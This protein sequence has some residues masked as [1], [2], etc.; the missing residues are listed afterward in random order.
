M[1]VPVTRGL[2]VAAAALG[3]VAAGPRLD[4]S[5]VQQPAWSRIGLIGWAAYSRAAD[6]G[7]GL[8][9]HPLVGAA[10]LVANL[11]AAVAAWLDPL[12]PR[13]PAVACSTAALLE[14]GHSLVRPRAAPDM[15]TVSRLVVAKAALRGALDCF[16]RW[17][18]IRAMLQALALA[19]DL[20]ALALAAADD[21]ALGAVE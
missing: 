2:I 13:P 10:T 3:G 14:V 16:T 1:S 11:A 8:V 15:L 18:G 12:T 19:A 5:L 7:A 9:F 6:L 21:R 17:H 4:K 20:W